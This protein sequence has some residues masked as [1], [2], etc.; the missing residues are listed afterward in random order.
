ASWPLRRSRAA[1]GGRNAPDRRVTAFCQKRCEIT[2]AVDILREA[3]QRLG[4]TEGRNLRIVLRWGAGDIVPIR[5]MAEELV[6]LKPD[7]ILGSSTPLAK[8]ILHESAEQFG[9]AAAV[10]R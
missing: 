3:L 5:A 7:V 9:A 4:W 8:A 10:S 1:L 2:H 6:A